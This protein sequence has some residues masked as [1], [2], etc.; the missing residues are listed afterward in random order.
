MKVFQKL[1]NIS[2]P[3]TISSLVSRKNFNISK[4]S[5]QHMFRN[6]ILNRPAPT[7][8]LPHITSSSS[9]TTSPSPNITGLSHSD[10]LFLPPSYPHK[11]F[12]SGLVSLSDK[13]RLL[14]LE[15]SSLGEEFRKILTIVFAKSKIYRYRNYSKKKFR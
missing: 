10:V 6:Y 3:N 12:L 9:I 7:I 11:N 13:Q 15:S 1:F 14:L 2:N 5:F 4:A 8:F